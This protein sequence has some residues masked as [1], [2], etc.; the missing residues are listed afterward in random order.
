MSYPFTDRW[1]T[2]STSTASSHP[3][4]SPRASRT[5]DISNDIP[6]P[7]FTRTFHPPTSS[8]SSAPIPTPA[9][10]TFTLGQPV[11]I[12]PGLVPNQKWLHRPARY[13]PKYKAKGKA[14][15]REYNGWRHEDGLGP[16]EK[17]GILVGLFEDAAGVKCARVRW[18]AR[19]GAVWG[20]EGPVD[21]EE[22]VAVS[23][24]TGEEGRMLGLID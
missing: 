14:A 21:A 9:P 8:S 6:H 2:A 23:W 22:P 17:V 11:V 19:P 16:E 18:L 7:S 24:K 4:A 10:L 3:T 1:P 5:K 20:E 12:G 13:A 15:A